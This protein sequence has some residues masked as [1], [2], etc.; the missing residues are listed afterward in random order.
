VRDAE[1]EDLAQ[2]KKSNILTLSFIEAKELI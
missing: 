2:K 1:P